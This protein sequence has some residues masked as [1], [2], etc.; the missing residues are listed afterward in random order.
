MERI[1]AIGPMSLAR[2]LE[3]FLDKLCHFEGFSLCVC[4]H[5]RNVTGIPSIY[6][7][8][9]ITFQDFA[10]CLNIKFFLPCIPINCEHFVHFIYVNRHNP[11]FPLNAPQPTN[12]DCSQNLLKSYQKGVAVSSNALLS[13]AAR[14][15]MPTACVE[16][17]S[18]ASNLYRRRLGL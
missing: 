14:S 16:G 4:N 2:S 10:K 18:L 6:S 5:N 3:L 11:I 9:K 7:S 1:R 17:Y 13:T 15:G 8:K 12:P